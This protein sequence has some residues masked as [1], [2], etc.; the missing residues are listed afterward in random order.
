MLQVVRGVSRIRWK[1]ASGTCTSWQEERS[2]WPSTPPS[3]SRQLE[4]RVGDLD[5]LAGGEVQLAK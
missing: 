2:S 1:M 4:D 3:S 5:Q